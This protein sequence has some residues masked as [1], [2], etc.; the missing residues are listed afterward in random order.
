MNCS[1]K[2]KMYGGFS[3]TTPFDPFCTIRGNFNHAGDFFN[4]NTFMSK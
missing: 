3:G 2:K 1:M 4:N